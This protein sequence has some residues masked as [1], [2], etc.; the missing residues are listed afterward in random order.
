M[1]LTV[2]TCLHVYMISTAFFYIP[3]CLTQTELPEGLNQTRLKSILQGYGEYPAKYRYRRFKADLNIAIVHSWCK[4][5]FS[6]VGRET[7]FLHRYAGSQGQL[8]KFTETKSRHEISVS[9]Y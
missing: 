4:P 2:C 1:A 9:S 8:L 3:N 7:F 6:S 5:L